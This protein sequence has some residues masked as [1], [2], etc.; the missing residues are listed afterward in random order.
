[1]GERNML[2]GIPKR[3]TGIHWAGVSDGHSGKPA[4]DDTETLHAKA[5][6]LEQ[7]S[8]SS[9]IPEF[10]LEEAAMTEEAAFHAALPGDINRKNSLGT[11]SVMLAESSGNPSEVV[12]IGNIVLDDLGRDASPGTI[13]NIQDRISVAATQYRRN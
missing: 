1:M 6:A 3:E 5:L 4:D 2:W 13:R 9:D 8:Y 7:E 11:Y 10:V 12:R